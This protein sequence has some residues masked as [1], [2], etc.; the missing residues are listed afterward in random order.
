MCLSS[1]HAFEDCLNKCSEQMATVNEFDQQEALPWRRSKAPDAKVLAMPDGPRRD[2]L[3][4][5][6][7]PCSHIKDR[8]RIAA[9]RRACA[10][11]AS[12]RLAPQRRPPAQDAR[13]EG[14]PRAR[15]NRPRALAVFLPEVMAVCRATSSAEESSDRRDGHRR[16]RAPADLRPA[17]WAD[18]CRRP[19]PGRR[20]IEDVFP[21]PKQLVGA[22]LFLLEVSGDSMIDAAICNGDY[23]VVRQEQTARTARSSP[24]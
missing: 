16:H 19:D 1:E 9:T 12:G 7:Q 10:R 4:P 13:G 17:A 2:R 14:L 23:V 21:L 3:T 24:P 22:A 5:R 8:S 6:Q 20:A 11:S 15:P 18:R